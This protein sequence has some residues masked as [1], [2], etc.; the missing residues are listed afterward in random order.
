MTFNVS[1]IDYNNNYEVTFGSSQLMVDTIFTI[2][3][4]GHLI[5]IAIL[6]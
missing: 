6:P 1:V 5:L 3:T 4:K 2:V